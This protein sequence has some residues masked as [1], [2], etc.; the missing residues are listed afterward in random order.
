MYSALVTGITS[1]MV[2]IIAKLVSKELLEKVIETVV[3]KGVIYLAAKTEN[4]VDDELA[5][6]INEKLR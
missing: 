2:S 4:T 6:I 1:A 3:K 5:R